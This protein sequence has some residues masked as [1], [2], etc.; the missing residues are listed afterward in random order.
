M[1]ANRIALAVVLVIGSFGIAR[2][3][4]D[5]VGTC[6]IDD[7]R[8]Y[9]QLNYLNIEGVATCD[10]GKVNLRIYDGDGDNARFI[11]TTYAYIEGHSFHAIATNIEEPL[12]NI[13]LRYSVEPD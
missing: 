11:A 12:S 7:W 4:D 5:H 8:S 1:N 9:Q 10:S 3:C 2:A 6:Q 13:T